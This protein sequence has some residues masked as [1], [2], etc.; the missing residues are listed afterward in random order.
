M[1][2]IERLAQQIQAI[3]ED[4]RWIHAQQDVIAYVGYGY[5]SV[6]GKWTK[7]VD[8]IVQISSRLSIPIITIVF[9]SFVQLLILYL[10]QYLTLKSPSVGHTIFVGM[11]AQQE[12]CL[13]NNFSELA[14]TAVVLFD[15][16][17]L[18]PFFQ[19]EKVGFY[20]LSRASSEATSFSCSLALS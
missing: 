18:K 14:G 11:G 12:S 7:R 15:E 4:V 1:N 13:V 9:V 5:K 2:P 20:C 6:R 16:R 10:S 19:Q 17:S 3:S 8:Q